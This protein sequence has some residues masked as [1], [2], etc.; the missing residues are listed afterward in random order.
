[1][2][3]CFLMKNGSG[4]SDVSTYV[5]DSLILSIGEF[6][7]KQAILQNSLT[8]NN[9]F[10]VEMCGYYTSIPASD[11]KGR[12]CE[13]NSSNSGNSTL[14]FACS[15]YNDLVEL[16]LGGTWHSNGTANITMA[17]NEK[18]TITTVVDADT[19][20]ITI[21]DNGVLATTLSQSISSQTLNYIHLFQSSTTNG[22]T[23][24]GTIFSLRL[25]NKALT[26]SEIK[27][28]YEIDVQRYGD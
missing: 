22:R 10:T 24:N 3:D 28:N 5:K 1:M 20:I 6:N 2:A 9:S 21:Y 12:F 16:K 25:Y 19:D 4:N 27:A 26:M 13:L 15:L 8:V 23:L 11:G 14:W 7:Y 17:A 18:K